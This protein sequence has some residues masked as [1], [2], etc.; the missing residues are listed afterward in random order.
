MK[1]LLWIGGLAIS[2]SVLAAET[3]PTHCPYD[4]VKLHES[5]AADRAALA[6]RPDDIG[7]QAALGLDLVHLSGSVE[8]SHPIEAYCSAR[9][10]RDL[11]E[12]VRVVARA[13]GN[14]E[15]RETLYCLYTKAPWPLGSRARASAQF[16]AIRE[17]DPARAQAVAA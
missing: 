2:A 15:A 17:R 4:P 10:G 7:R 9:E 11:L 8:R 3:G 12:R 5:I 13:P 1:T 16:A 6:E 14:L